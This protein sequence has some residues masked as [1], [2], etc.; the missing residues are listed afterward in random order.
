MSDNDIIWMLVIIVSASIVFAINTLVS[1]SV[2]WAI[3]KAIRFNKQD[4]ATHLRV[5]AYSSVPAFVVLVIGLALV[6]LYVPWQ[7]DPQQG[8][9]ALVTL[10]AF[11]ALIYAAAS[12]YFIR[13]IYREGW[14][15]TTKA[16]TAYV[17]MMVVAWVL[18]S[19]VFSMILIIPSVIYG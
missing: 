3:S 15:K 16:Y 4:R 18:L 12:L 8:L 17:F 1:A 6:M 11:C 9:G 13:K 19:F 14:G 7:D 10:F 2:L 5:S